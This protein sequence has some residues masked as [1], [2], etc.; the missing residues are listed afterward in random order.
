MYTETMEEMRKQSVHD[1]YYFFCFKTKKYIFI[2]KTPR[3]N[4]YYVYESCVHLFLDSPKGIQQKVC[5]T[6][7]KICFWFILCFFV[8]K[9]AKTSMDLH[10]I[11][12]IQ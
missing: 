9:E 6:L 4:I 11:V 2:M 3:L 10:Q 7:F 8:G 12:A 1:S 5:I